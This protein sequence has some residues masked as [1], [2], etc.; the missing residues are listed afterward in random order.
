MNNAALIQNN[1]S[2]GDFYQNTLRLWRNSFYFI[3]FEETVLGKMFQ[4][5]L[6]GS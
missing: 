3:I 5:P 6:T 4:M 2:I 1:F